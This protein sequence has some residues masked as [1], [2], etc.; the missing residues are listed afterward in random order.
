MA[1]EL[2]LL[3]RGNST[4]GNENAPPVRTPKRD[5][6][7][8][9]WTD[10]APAIGLFAAIGA[11]LGLFTCTSWLIDRS[12]FFLKNSLDPS[13]RSLLWSS[14]LVGALV[15]G[16]IPVLLLVAS[17]GRAARAI[18]H[19]ADL[20]CP[21][22]LVGLLPSLFAHQL[23]STQPLTYLAQLG[24][25]VLLAERLVARMLEA[26]PS[27]FRALARVERFPR[28][29]RWL[30]L[31]VIV[32]ASA[33]YAAW[34]SYYTLLHHRRFGT[35][36]YDLGINVNWCYNA[37]HGNL[38][39]STVEFGPDG[40]NVLAGHAIF[41]MFLWLPLYALHPGAEV[42]LIYQSVMCG[43]AAIP[44]YLTAKELL[45]RSAALVV[46]LGYLMFAPLHGPNFYD[47][48]ELPVALP[49]HFCLHY[50]II[51]RRYRWVPLLLFILYAHRED[52]SVGLTVLG[53][54]LLLTRLRP[55]L[56]LVLCIVSPL[57]F[58]AI[59]F[60]LMPAVGSWW[61]ADMYKEL[62]PSGSTGYGPIVQTV[63]I[64]PV[65]FLHTLLTEQKLIY[66]LHLFAPLVF[67]PF[68]RPLL[69]MLAMPG[70]FFTLM[71]T[72]YGPTLSIAFQYTTH[73]IPYLF[74]S[75]IF[76]LRMINE[77]FGAARLSGAIAAIALGVLSHSTT[78]GAVIQHDT[79]IGGFSRIVFKE[80]ESDKRQYAE[81]KKLIAKI[82]Q[83]A[84]VGATERE[85][86]HIGARIDAY[87]L[88]LAHG[89][90]DYLLIRAGEVNDIIRDAFRRNPYG[91]VG[92]AGGTFYLFKKRHESPKT[93]WAKEK[94]GIP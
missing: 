91:F 69:A 43:L 93:K 45:P 7:A 61:F 11:S 6:F 4:G 70:F 15:A 49:F 68:R 80:S 17:R 51:T 9:P 2:S 47:Y 8:L 83:E 38:F 5:F 62:Q 63:L 27:L 72:S 35:A 64:N 86:P 13:L 67:L 22:I 32:L 94:L 55:R 59:K 76:S 88:R 12:S 79:F 25:V 54:F 19:A 14:V 44:L 3:T 33:A 1:Y 40:G 90:A 78:F 37:L 28:V 57:V 84:S 39:R 92:D 20:A 58:V 21:L 60:A 73:W 75:T 74:L 81:F 65:Y 30:P 34:F 89:E 66:F 16:V 48:H 50:V 23:W 71:T 82:P 41:A 31:A 26:T 46:A 87:T 53:A 29:R 85:T 24:A 77:R 52:V 42:L 18:T 36:A 56:G 10:S